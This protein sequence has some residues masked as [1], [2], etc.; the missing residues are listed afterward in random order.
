MINSGNSDAIRMISKL[1]RDFQT[2][3]LPKPQNKDIASN[4]HNMPSIRGYY[5]VINPQTTPLNLPYLTARLIWT[6]N[7]TLYTQYPAHF[8]E[9]NKCFSE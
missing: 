3:T 4:S 2:Q 6:E 9:I 5:Q 7:D 8:G 1:V